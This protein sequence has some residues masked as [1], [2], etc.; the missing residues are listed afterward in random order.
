MKSVAPCIASTSISLTHGSTDDFR[1]RTCLICKL[2]LTRIVT[3][4]STI[5]IESC[6]ESH[7][8]FR[9]LATVFRDDGSIPRLSGQWAWFG[10]HF[11]MA[12]RIAFQSVAVCLVGFAMSLTPQV[13]QARW[14][15]GGFHGGGFHGGGFRG[16]FYGGGF[17][18]SFYGGGI[19]AGRSGFYGGYRGFYP[20]YYGGFSPRYYRGYSPRYYGSYIMNPGYYGVGYGG[21]GYSGYPANYGNCTCG[22]YSVSTGGYAPTTLVSAATAPVSSRLVS[23]NSGN[24]NPAL[25][26]YLKN[27][28]YNSPRIQTQTLISSRTDIPAGNLPADNLN[29]K[30]FPAMVTQKTLDP[31][32]APSL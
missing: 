32:P 17:G 18:R 22:T 26:Y 30:Y 15:G 23:A 4:G 1:N 31:P 11:R 14:H 9:D 20:R 6:A 27:N 5:E 8:D 12:P 25:A 3:E 28:P 16:G 21:Y 19:Y 24:S 10:R 2:P 7:E 29:S 13:A